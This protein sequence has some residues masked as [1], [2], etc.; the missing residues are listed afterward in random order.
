MAT[1]TTAAT[2]VAAPA[3]AANVKTPKAAF[4]LMKFAQLSIVPTPTPNPD[5]GFE[6]TTSLS[7]YSEAKEDAKTTKET[8]KTTKETDAKTP[9]VVVNIKDW[10]V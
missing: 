1:A 4:M 8:T 7:A 2:T 6:L 9:H 5:P 3:V 10:V